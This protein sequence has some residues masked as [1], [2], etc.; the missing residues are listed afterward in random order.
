MPGELW[1]IE[2]TVHRL[3]EMP[4]SLAEM[5]K[6]RTSFWKPKSI[7]KAK[8]LSHTFSEGPTSH[9]LGIVYIETKK[10][11][12]WCH[13]LWNTSLAMVTF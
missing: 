9:Q 5:A 7:I 12:L 2:L 3:E 4:I 8:H 11:T 6:P 13:E 10:V 1:M